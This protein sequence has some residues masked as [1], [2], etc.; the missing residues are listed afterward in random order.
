MEKRST[1]S[2]FTEGLLKASMVLYF[3]LLLFP[4]DTVSIFTSEFWSGLVNIFYFVLF[5]VL[6]LISIIPVKYTFR[7]VFVFIISISSFFKLLMLLYDSGFQSSI[8][9]YLLLFSLCIYQMT[10]MYLKQKGR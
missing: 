10:R 5:I 3:F 7:V 6:S 4:T 9:P 8:A 2:W 1:L